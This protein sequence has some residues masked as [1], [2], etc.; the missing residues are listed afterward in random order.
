MTFVLEAFQVRKPL[1]VSAPSAMLLLVSSKRTVVVHSVFQDSRPLT[2]LF[3][4]HWGSSSTSRAV[5]LLKRAA[6][7][8]YVY[9]ALP[10]CDLWAGSRQVWIWTRPQH[11][12]AVEPG[13]RGWSCLSQ[14]PPYKNHDMVPRSEDCLACHK[15]TAQIFEKDKLVV[16]DKLPGLLVWPLYKH[17]FIWSDRLE[18]KYASG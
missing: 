8:I 6:W 4:H 12:I 3:W 14:E 5:W 15:L 1:S 7:W 9:V 2:T 10:H 13:I 11:V 17:I 16:V 18:T